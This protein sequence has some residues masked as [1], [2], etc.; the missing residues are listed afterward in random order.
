[1]AQ[2]TIYDDLNVSKHMAKWAIFRRKIFV[3]QLSDWFL[4]T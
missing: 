3:D 4:C 2:G 1:M